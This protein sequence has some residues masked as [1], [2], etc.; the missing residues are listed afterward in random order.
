[1]LVDVIPK[2]IWQQSIN[3]VDNWCQ[4]V[5][6]AYQRNSHVKRRSPV[7]SAKVFS[8]MGGGLSQ[9]KHLPNGQLQEDIVVFAQ[10]NWPMMFS[11]FFEAVKE[12]GPD[13]LTSNIILAVNWTGLFFIND[14]EEV[15]VGNNYKIVNININ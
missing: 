4:L 15:L 3:A 10:L 9:L 8:K 6:A 7:I 11:R 13:M 1:M 2:D 14:Q 12:S 5:S